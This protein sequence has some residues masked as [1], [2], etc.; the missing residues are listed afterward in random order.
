LK[1]CT[2]TKYCIVDTK[3]MFFKI[4]FGGIF[5]FFFIQLSALLHLPP[6]RFHCAD[7]CWDRTHDRCNLCNVHWQPDALTTR[8]DLI[9]NY[10]LDLI[11]NYRLDLIRIRLDLIRSR[12]DLIRSRLDLIRT[13]L[14]L[15]H[16]RLDLI[17]I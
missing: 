17:R 9:H 8:I 16:T 1:C 3:Y 13:R 2:G 4:F 15:I 6:L 14:D 10:R 11:R 5:L 7:G 12:L